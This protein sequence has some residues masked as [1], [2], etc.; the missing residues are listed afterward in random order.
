MRVYLPDGNIICSTHT[1]NLDIPTHARMVHIFPQLTGSLIS[2]GQLCDVGCVAI[3]NKE[4]MHVTDKTGKIIMQGTRCPT[5]KL[6]IVELQQRQSQSNIVEYFHKDDVMGSPTPTT[7][8]V[9]LQNGFID[10]PGLSRDIFRRHAT[11]TQEMAR[12]H[13]DQT[14]SGI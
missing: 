8:L 6:W 7:M 13:L 14:R 4:N 5:T 2:I 3:Y 1:A 10:F 12:G 9:A 11:Y